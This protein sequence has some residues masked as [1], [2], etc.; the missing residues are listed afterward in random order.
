[1]WSWYSCKKALLALQK[2]DMAKFDTTLIKLFAQIKRLTTIWVYLLNT[3]CSE[4]WNN[5]VKSSDLLKMLKVGGISSVTRV[6][7][8]RVTG[9]STH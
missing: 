7:V 5:T 8:T 9:L 3:H 6:T 2:K 4:V 1:M